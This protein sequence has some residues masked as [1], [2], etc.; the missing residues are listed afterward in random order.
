MTY[1][2]INDAYT[3]FSD[4]FGSDHPNW[5]RDQLQDW[6]HEHNLRYEDLTDDL[7]GEAYDQAIRS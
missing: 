2:T 3:A 5:S 6:I 7:L 4:L 1:A